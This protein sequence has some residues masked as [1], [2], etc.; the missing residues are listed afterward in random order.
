MYIFDGINSFKFYKICTV[1]T[2]IVLTFIAVYIGI[3]N[4][5][6]KL[7]FEIIC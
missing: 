7:S 5:Y 6:R 3:S 2:D 1:A 4:I